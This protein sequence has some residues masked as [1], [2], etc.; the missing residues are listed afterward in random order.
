MCSLCNSTRNINEEEVFKTYT[1]HYR[2]TECMFPFWKW[3]RIN[4]AWGSFQN[5][6]I[7]R[8]NEHNL[9]PMFCGWGNLRKAYIAQSAMQILC[10]PFKGR[11]THVVGFCCGTPFHI[12][13]P[14]ARGSIT[15]PTF[16][17]LRQTGASPASSTRAPSQHTRR[18]TH[19]VH[20]RCHWFTC[21]PT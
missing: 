10:V 12:R 15:L 16:A 19:C 9:L 17:P 5:V 21:G 18:Y 7:A 3:T 20:W 14:S 4:Y 13:P 11:H 1:S 6:H 8:S 2:N